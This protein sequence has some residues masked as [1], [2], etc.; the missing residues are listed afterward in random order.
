MAFNIQT[1]LVRGVEG[2]QFHEGGRVHRNL[3]I[4]LE[5]EDSHALDDVAYV[6]YE[7]HPTFSERIRVSNNRKTQF[8]IK[9]WAYG[10]FRIRAKLLMKDGSLQL[11]DGFVRW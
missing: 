3:R 4:Y 2:K 6:K 10:H 11:A 1:E 7:L 5:A 9:I 8:D